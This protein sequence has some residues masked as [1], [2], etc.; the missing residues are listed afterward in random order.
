MAERGR[1]QVW[2]L[3]IGAGLFVLSW[4][5]IAQIWI[6]I[7]G[8]TDGDAADLRASV[9]AGQ[10]TIGFVGLA[11][12]GVAAKDAVRSAGW[13]RL[14]RTLWTMLRKGALPG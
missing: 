6:W 10:W 11:L 2:Q 1:R 7:A 5:P 12:A 9:W 8:L 14:P 13:R 4:L 3:R